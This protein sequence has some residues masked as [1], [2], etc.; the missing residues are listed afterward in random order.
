MR[1]VPPHCIGRCSLC[2]SHRHKHAH[3]PA[4]FFFHIH[5]CYLTLFATFS[6][7]IDTK[8]FLFAPLRTYMHILLLSHSPYHTPIL[9]YAP[10]HTFLACPPSICFFI[11]PHKVCSPLFS[12]SALPWGGD[13][14]WHRGVCTGG[15]EIFSDA[16]QT[17]H[18]ADKADGLT[19]PCRHTN[20]Y[21]HT[22]THAH[23]NRH[24]QQQLTCYRLSS[25]CYW[26]S[27]YRS[28]KIPFGA[29]QS[30]IQC[31]IQILAEVWLFTLCHKKS[32]L[33]ANL[34]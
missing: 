33:M 20:T 25:T 27:S 28:M 30:N 1:E 19:G 10:I 18:P 31:I 22:V 8:H 17:S 21:T 7:H 15:E 11:S 16:M 12:P 26:H 9:T 34:T 3:T 2:V 13:T 6:A 32:Y 5:P 29:H 14:L 23:S 4:S 24:T